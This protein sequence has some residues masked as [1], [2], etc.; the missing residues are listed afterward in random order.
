MTLAPSIIIII[1]KVQIKNLN[2]CVLMYS[3]GNG[4]REM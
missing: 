4:T 2:N 3:Q 1:F